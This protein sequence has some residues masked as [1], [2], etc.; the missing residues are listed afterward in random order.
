MS[1]ELLLC[2]FSYFFIYIIYL[3]CGN[4]FTS[5]IPFSFLLL[6]II[7]ITIRN[8]VISK[9]AFKELGFNYD[10]I[11]EIPNF[12]DVNDILFLTHK[13]F[14][15]KKS[16]KL[17]LM[18]LKLKGLI[19]IKNE[20]GK[21]IIDKLDKMGNFSTAEQNILNYIASE[22]TECF[23]RVNYNK[24]VKE[25]IIK[26][27]LAYNENDLGFFKFYFFFSSITFLVFAF[28]ILYKSFSDFNFEI[29]PAIVAGFIL[30]VFPN[31]VFY[32]LDRI[33][34][35][36]NLKLTYKGYAYKYL[37]NKYKK[38]LKDFSRI[39]KL[40]NENYPLWEKHLLYAQA[41]NINLDY[42][43]IPDVNLKLLTENELNYLFEKN[44][45]Y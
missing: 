15:N 1:A 35:M 41:L 24:C 30:I 9:K 38:F 23:S 4:Y 21:T 16:I 34:H 27:G 45:K 37:I 17:M 39:D 2:I 20:N 29:S 43:K 6:S 32:Y 11:R 28:I 13:S 25:D 44:S 7:I 8:K 22:N 12:L 3:L 19:E 10:Y 36:L 33:N 31:V 18:Q 14:L 40:K 26:K 5:I 42:H